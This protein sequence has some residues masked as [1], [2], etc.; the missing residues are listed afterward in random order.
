MRAT[1][2]AFVLFGLLVADVPAQFVHGVLNTG[3]TPGVRHAFSHGGAIFGCDAAGDTFAWNGDTLTWSANGAATIPTGTA[4]FLERNGIATHWDGTQLHDFDGSTWN[5]VATSGTP[6]PATFGNFA[7]AALPTGEVLV[8]GGF[9]TTNQVFV[10]TTFRLS[11]GNVWSQLSPTTS[12]SARENAGM[13]HDGAG[14]FVLF[15][16]DNN[17]G[18]LADTWLFNG[19]NWS[20]PSVT[21]SP[22]ARRLPAMCFRSRINAIVMFGGDNNGTAL[23]DHWILSGTTWT[24][25]TVSFTPSTTSGIHHA[26]IDAAKDEIVAAEFLGARTFVGMVSGDRVYGNGCVCGGQTSAFGIDSTGT[27]VLSSAFTIAFSN[28]EQGNA[29]WLAFSAGEEPSPSQISG[30]PTGCVNNIALAGSG[31][32]L[33]TASASGTPTY[34]VNVP[35][36]TSTIGV[37]VFYQGVQLNLSTFTGCASNGLEVQVGRQ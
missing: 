8:F 10:N 17:S 33:V 14:N 26:P 36:T 30:L 25:Q 12:P 11:T 16:G 27:V 13:T 7:F 4:I 9:D 37:R 22:T 1:Q 6:P 32:V 31:S 20:Q 21:G 2:L 18:F 5:A 24:S 3:N 28:C 15:G 19:T 34:S 23:A 35:S 29:L